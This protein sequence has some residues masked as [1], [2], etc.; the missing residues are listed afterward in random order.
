LFLLLW[1]SLSFK[2]TLLVLANVV[3]PQ[4]PS[5]IALVSEKPVTTVIQP[6]TSM[7]ARAILPLDLAHAVFVLLTLVSV[8]L[9]T[10]PMLDNAKIPQTTT[11][12]S[13]APLNAFMQEVL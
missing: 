11:V 1:S 8:K 3:S 10:L 4:L 12:Y 6:T 13:V 9:V 5:S 2:S 7:L